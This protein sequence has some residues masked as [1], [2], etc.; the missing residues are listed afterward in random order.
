MKFPY[1]VL[2][3]TFIILSYIPLTSPCRNQSKEDDNT[4][5]KYL[6]E[7]F[8]LLKYADYEEC[9]D[10]LLNSNKFDSLEYL[11]KEISKRNIKVKSILDNKIKL[12]NQKLNNLK[13]KYRFKE[14]DYKKV[15]P[16]LRWAQSK[17][18]IIIDIKFSED[19]KIQGIL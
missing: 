16:Y 14:H 13:E 4:I 6:Q 3:L 8:N 7:N 9:T 12:Y 15:S 5:I 18:Y 1:I 17:E 2:V 11:L 10:V 19:I